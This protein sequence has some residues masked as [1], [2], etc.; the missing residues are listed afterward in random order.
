MEVEKS[1]IALIGLH[2]SVDLIVGV[3]QKLFYIT[4]SNLVR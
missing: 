4:S 1:M 3:T 2:R